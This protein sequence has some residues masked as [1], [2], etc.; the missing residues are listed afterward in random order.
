MPETKVQWLLC[1][2]RLVSKIDNIM[3]F[4]QLVKQASINCYFF[5]EVLLWHSP[6]S[7]ITLRSH[8]NAKWCN[9]YGQNGQSANLVFHGRMA[10]WWSCPRTEWPEVKLLL[11]VHPKWAPCN[12]RA[13]AP[14]SYKSI[15]TGYQFLAEMPETKVQWLLCVDRLVQDRQWQAWKTS[16][17]WL[18]CL[19]RGF[20]MALTS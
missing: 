7:R 15:D 11:W 14:Q 12:C 9:S 18:L 13:K 2:S 10:K 3:L 20:I 16:K 17:C 19:S 6:P 1:L 5:L 4:A 8:Q